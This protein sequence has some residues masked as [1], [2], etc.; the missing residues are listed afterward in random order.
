VSIAI[1]QGVY[2]IFSKVTEIKFDAEVRQV[3]TMADGTVNLVLNLPEYA[4]A[5]AQWFLAHIGDYC[6]VTAEE[7]K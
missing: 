1:K 2:I 6:Q 4:I 7:K 3:K 5:Q